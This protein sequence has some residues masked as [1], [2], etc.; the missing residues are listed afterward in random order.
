MYHATESAF[1]VA[2][3]INKT[4][5]LCGEWWCK[6]RFS[7]K[8]AAP[9]VPWLVTC[10]V[11]R[12]SCRLVVGW[13]SLCSQ[14][15]RGTT[16]FCRGVFLYRAWLFIS[17]YPCVHTMG[18][19]GPVPQMVPPPYT[20]V[21]DISDTSGNPLEF[22]A[23]GCG[24]A[25]HDSLGLRAA[26]PTPRKSVFLCPT[27]RRY[28]TGQPSHTH[29]ASCSV[30]TRSRKLPLEIGRVCSWFND[31]HGEK[32]A[33]FRVALAPMYY[34]SVAVSSISFTMSLL[35]VVGDVRIYVANTR[36]SE[37]RASSM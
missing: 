17:R 3:I 34:G 5:F 7:G 1:G 14:R 20:H 26:R 12:E 6:R 24:R 21:P 19:V 23:R 15:L 30:K 2:S 18:A 22:G 4:Q 37:Q 29:G 28:V 16:P 13:Y 33:R 32:S 25:T 31:S 8:G 9:T 27:P 10:V 11:M 36:L 35:D